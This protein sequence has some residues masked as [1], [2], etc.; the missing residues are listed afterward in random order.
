MLIVGVRAVTVEPA[1]NVTR[2]VCFASSIT[3][4]AAGD[5]ILKLV[6]DLSLF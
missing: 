1:G 2:I 3:P 6:I 5:V 4:V